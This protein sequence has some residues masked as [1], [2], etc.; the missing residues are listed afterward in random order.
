MAEEKKHTE[1]SPSKLARVLLCPGS[2]KLA[3][4][5]PPSGSNAAAERGTRLHDYTEKVINGEMQLTDIV[6]LEE[7]AQVEFAVNSLQ[8]LILKWSRKH[9]IGHV[10]VLTEQFL[11]IVP[12][13]VSGTTDVVVYCDEF[14]AIVDFKFGH[15][16]VEAEQN[17][18][19]MAYAVGAYKKFMIDD[20][21]ESEVNDRPVYLVVIQPPL[22]VVDEWE[23]SSGELRMW[24]VNLMLPAVHEA[25]TS[26]SP[27]I[28][29]GEVQCRW[30]PAIGVCPEAH[31]YVQEQAS[32]V[33]AAHAKIDTLDPIELSKVMCII[34][35]LEEAIKALKDAAMSMAG[36]N[37]LPGFKL[38]RG[39]GNRKWLDENK[40]LELLNN[41]EVEEKL[42][43]KGIQFENLIDAK[44]KS[45][46][47][48]EKI[49]G[50]AFFAKLDGLAD[51]IDRSEGKVSLVT[52]DDERPNIV[53]NPFADFAMPE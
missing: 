43:A 3:R 46:S 21:T 44:L 24:Y 5:V 31:T 34:P 12:D 19:L 20:K 15:N 52:E 11:E 30:C 38:V 22:D 37:E 18:Q 39:K 28:I 4:Q 33:F 7:R 16:K 53:T 10:Q 51:C 2:V 45:P 26:P 8:D 27:R 25:L 48:I 42:A 23:L 50:K 40:A 49:V 41:P 17:N 29:Q 32:K 14:L 47:Q 6:D 35:A 13:V 36:R 9:D 1:I